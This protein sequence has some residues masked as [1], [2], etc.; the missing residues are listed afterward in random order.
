MFTI[1][2]GTFII[3]ATIATTTATRVRAEHNACSSNLAVSLTGCCVTVP[4][5][6]LPP[7]VSALPSTIMRVWVCRTLSVSLGRCGLVSMRKC[8]PHCLGL[9][10]FE[11]RYKTEPPPPLALSQRLPSQRNPETQNPEDAARA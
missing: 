5:A 8:G 9:A 11:A 1:I 3:I 6:S 4:P 7:L 10:S 2:D